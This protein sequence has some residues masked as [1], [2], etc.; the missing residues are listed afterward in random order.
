MPTSNSKSEIS[1][2]SS[3][4]R[5]IALEKARRYVLKPITITMRFACL[6]ALGYYRFFKSWKLFVFQN[7]SY[8]YFY[9]EYNKTWLNERAVEI[10]IVWNIVKKREGS[11]LEIGNVLSHYFT[12]QHDVVDKYEKGEGVINEDVADLRL[13]NKY[14]LVVSIS[15]IEHVGWDEN[16]TDKKEKIN[17]P[18]KTLQAIENLKKLINLNGMLVITVPFGSNP[19]LDHLLKSGKIKFDRTLCMKRISTDNRW[20]ETEFKDIESSLYGYPFP[21]ANGLIIG[22]INS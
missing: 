15:T 11:V 4:I 20:I 8:R 2:F 18:E 6:L 13:Q 5:E 1:L 22:I 19:N 7:K 12:F 16:P 9:H 21:Y 3:K 17:A 14:D 10:P